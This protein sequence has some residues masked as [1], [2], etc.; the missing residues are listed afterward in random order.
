MGWRLGCGKMSVYIKDPKDQVRGFLGNS[1]LTL[2]RRP[3]C[4]HGRPAAVAM[5]SCS[6][7]RPIALFCAGLPIVPTDGSIGGLFSFLPQRK[8]SNPVE[9][10]NASGTAEM[11]PGG[12]A[13]HPQRRWAGHRAGCGCTEITGNQAGS[14]PGCGC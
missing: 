13:V 5:L 1:N 10:E 9:I 3:N 7:L 14:P 4:L 8:S 2:A 6:L 12:S 11:L